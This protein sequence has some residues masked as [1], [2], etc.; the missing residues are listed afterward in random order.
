MPATVLRS[1]QNT[2]NTGYPGGT[3]PTANQIIDV[4]AW[5]NYLQ[6]TKTP[7][8]NAIGKGGARDQRPFYFGQSVFTPHK[9]TLA[10]NV[11]NNAT[12]VTVNA[13]DGALFQVNSAF[14]LFDQVTGSNPPRYDYSAK[15]LMWVTAIA[16]DVLTVVRAQGGT[17]GIA[18]TSGASIELLAPHEPQ[19]Q[20]HTI[21]PTTR[22]YQ[23]F[24]HFSRIAGGIKMDRAFQNMPTY[25][26]KSDQLIND[27]NKETVR[28]K[29]LL[30]KTVVHGGRQAGNPSTPLP[31][32]MGGF[33]SF[34]TSNVYNQGGQTLSVASLETAM[35]DL[36]N[37]V[38]ESAKKT[39][40]MSANTAAVFDTFLNPYRQQFSNETEATYMMDSVK[41]RW[42]T[43]NI[44][45]TR[46]MPD[47]VIAVVDWAEMSLIPFKG[48]D[49][50]TMDHPVN[51][52]YVW[53]SISADFS[54]M[55]QNEA[56]MGIITNFSTDLN[57]YAGRSFLS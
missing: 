21:S 5:A 44:G 23:N 13:G 36:F 39:Y 48:L 8:L 6:P 37:K 15:E 1:S 20:D 34:I 52:D 43:Y 42:G 31:E 9:S 29:L 19:L 40:A 4:A 41:M 30:E 57:S 35:R 16:G 53:R 38:D 18:H 3:V 45:V 26:T 22:G 50:H 24:N 27:M 11:A 33:L 55:V 14:A 49:W 7:I 56:A 17:A 2:Y 12:T 10:A 54:L 47:G 28:L 46:W 51:G 32:M 25:E